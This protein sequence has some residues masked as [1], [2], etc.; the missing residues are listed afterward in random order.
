MNIGPKRYEMCS[1][2]RMDNDQIVYKTLY[3]GVRYYTDPDY[4]TPTVCQIRDLGQKP[5]GQVYGD[6]KR[7]QKEDL[8]RNLAGGG[9]NPQP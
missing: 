1:E 6:P 2:V 4:F 3:W 7:I 8:D 9:S 5:T